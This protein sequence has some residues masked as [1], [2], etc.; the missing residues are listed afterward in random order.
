MALMASTHYI[1]PVKPDTDSIKGLKITDEYAS[2]LVRPTNN[3]KS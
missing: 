1:I 3:Y 2:K